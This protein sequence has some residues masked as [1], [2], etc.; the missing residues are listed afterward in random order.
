MSKW[1]KRQFVHLS[2]KSDKWTDGRVGANGLVGSLI[3]SDT[4]FIAEPI[5][6]FGNMCFGHNISYKNPAPRTTEDTKNKE[7]RP[8]TTTDDDGHSDSSSNFC[9]QIDLILPKYAAPQAVKAILSKRA[10]EQQ[11][12]DTGRTVQICSF[13]V[14]ENRSNNSEFKVNSNK[15]ADKFGLAGTH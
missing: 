4:R 10:K 12:G 8:Q 7:Q 1:A 13:V 14:S 15:W 5:N 6:I 3:E 9:W 11:S 2:K